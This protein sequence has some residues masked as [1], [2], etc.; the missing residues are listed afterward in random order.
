MSS[1]LNNLAARTLNLA[2]LAQPRLSSR[3]ETRT[4]SETFDSELPFGEQL[5]ETERSNDEQAASSA[6]RL[7]NESTLN[8]RQT[9][10]V[11]GTVRRP[12]VRLNDS[13]PS[14]TAATQWQV[15]RQVRQNNSVQQADNQLRHDSAS[16]PPATHLPVL[17]IKIESQN[18]QA[19]SPEA[20]HSLTEKF[21]TSAKAST[22]NDED[23]ARDSFMK[24]D[25][26]ALERQIRHLIAEHLNSKAGRQPEDAARSHNLS[27]SH[28]V[29]QGAS[30]SASTQAPTIRVTIG[31]IEV[32]AVTSSPQPQQSRPAP[33]RPVP[34]LSL[35]DYLKQRSG[36]RR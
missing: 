9:L 7:S 12:T 15:I 33:A 31:R 36:G 4:R 8:N 30:Q 6:R 23:A 18:S 26:S 1:F 17:P 14:A 2:A 5:I 24:E 34:Q 35:A 16:S 29:F 10:T 11:E 25:G 3:F 32:R 27:E 22:P 21:L 20:E 13:E 19:L 28:D